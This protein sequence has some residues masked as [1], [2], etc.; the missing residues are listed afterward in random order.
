M[1]IAR[2]EALIAGLGLEEAL[3]R[4]KAYTEHVDGIMIHSKHKD[5]AEIFAFIDES[6]RR[7]SLAT[8]LE[9]ERMC[10]YFVC[11]VRSSLQSSIGK[12]EFAQCVF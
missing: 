6:A 4:A 2:L 7:D 1:I 10:Q 8:P 9:L 12:L 11:V 5:P 3:T